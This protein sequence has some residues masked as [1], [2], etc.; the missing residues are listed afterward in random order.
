M[1]SV[2]DKP[3]AESLG[4]LDEALRLLEQE[5]RAVTPSSEATLA[6]LFDLVQR[7]LCA[8]SVSM[9][10]RVA[11]DG[12]KSLVPCAAVAVAV[13][14]RGT[15]RVE[16]VA[17]V[18][19]FDRN[20]EQIARYEAVCRRL[21]APSAELATSNSRLVRLDGLICL[22]LG[23]DDDRPTAVCLI[24]GGITTGADAADH[25]LELIAESISRPLSVRLAALQGAGRRKWW[26]RLRHILRN[27]RRVA[28]LAAA[29]LAAGACLPVPYQVHCDCEL[30]P[31]VRRHVVAPFD[32]VL[33]KSFCKPGDVVAAGQILARL[34]AKEL[35]WE[36]ASVT[37]D[38][39]RAEKSRDVNFSSGKTAASQI[40][41]LDARRLDER[42]KL[43]E[44]RLSHLDVKS[45]IA[46][47]V[48]SGDLDRAEGAPVKL[49]RSLFEV[50]PL[51]EM[52][53]E[54]LVPET[55]IDRVRVGQEVDISLDAM[56]GTTLNGSIAR[57]YPRAEI[58][59]EANVFV[60]EV[61][62]S[63]DD[64]DLRPGMKGRAA[65]RTDRAPLAWVAT[66][67]LFETI[68]RWLW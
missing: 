68:S 64:G 26:G 29:V 47:V 17:Q 43:L 57:I 42:R 52:V 58:R 24:D 53:V 55:E 51:D 37:A 8:T 41:R 44:H 20:S 22:P 45:P 21:L 13:V 39:D 2:S 16:A 46:G 7:V 19:Q 56:P 11:A 49:G 35:T 33:D 63:N 36:L 15:C 61:T 9:A 27:N 25:V 23:G 59:R 65:V 5:G 4:R 1:S 28:W 38:R 40:D 50:S 3:A 12:W 10:C 66:H 60:A 30:Q 6:A 18:D 14:R 32:G 67:R 62:M 54:V 31:V 34:D 48:V